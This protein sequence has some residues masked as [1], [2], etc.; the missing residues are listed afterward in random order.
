MN[1]KNDKLKRH[2]IFTG[3]ILFGPVLIIVGTIGV[4]SISPY[5]EANFFDACWP[6]CEI[7]PRSVINLF[8]IFGL[9]V[10][11]I[12]LGS[13]MIISALSIPIGTLQRNRRNRS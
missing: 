9:P 2:A 3:L 13:F 1:S 7:V 11:F 5:R 8:G 4:S 10:I 12:I 6:V